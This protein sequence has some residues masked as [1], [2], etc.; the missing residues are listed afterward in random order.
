[1]YKVIEKLG[2]K[3]GVLFITMV[4]ALHACNQDNYVK[5][6][7]N[8]GEEIEKNMQRSIIYLQHI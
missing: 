6:E 8:Y 1:M 4:L 3:S 5:T 2:V 7:A